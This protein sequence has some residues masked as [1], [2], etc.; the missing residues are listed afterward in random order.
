MW[1]LSYGHNFL[2][3]FS[4][5]LRYVWNRSHMLI[6]WKIVF[7]PLAKQP[8]RS[9]WINHPSSP[10]LLGTSR[11][12]EQQRNICTWFMCSPS[13]VRIESNQGTDS[14]S[15]FRFANTQNRRRPIRGWGVWCVVEGWMALAT[16]TL[17]LRETMISFLMR[18]PDFCGLMKAPFFGELI[19][20]HCN[21]YRHTINYRR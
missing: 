9:L 1:S 19:G 16:I 11:T 4:H 14:F 3:Q 6:W 7:Y 2:S 10:T 5:L 15:H 18:Y 13:S 12:Y 8:V 17:L 20:R 21:N